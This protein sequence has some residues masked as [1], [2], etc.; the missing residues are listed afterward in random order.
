MFS[1]K[2]WC[3]SLHTFWPSDSLFVYSRHTMLEQSFRFSICEE[4]TRA[5]SSEVMGVASKPARN[6]SEGS[7]PVSSEVAPGWMERIV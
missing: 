5:P 4:N 2:R 3:V 7:T 1:E 6:P